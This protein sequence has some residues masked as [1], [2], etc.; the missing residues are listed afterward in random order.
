MM[1]KWIEAGGDYQIPFMLAA[2]KVLK[3]EPVRCPKCDGASLRFY[4]H[5][6]DQQRKRGTIWVWCP[7]CFTKCHLPR[8][9]LP[10]TVLADPFADLNLDQFAE[11]EIDSKEPFSDRLNRM[12]KEGK[13]G[14]P[15]FG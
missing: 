12:W 10:N 3:G 15:L 9:S 4:S 1:N 11:L 2:Q 14:P 6:F 5:I 8:V 7:S 13:L